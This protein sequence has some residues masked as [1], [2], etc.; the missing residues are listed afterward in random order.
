D[1][2]TLDAVVIDGYPGTRMSTYQQAGRAGRGDDPALVV[3]VGG[4]D[5]LDQYLMQSPGDFFEGD[6]ERAVCDPE[7][8]HLLPL[9]VECAAAENWLS[10][11]DDAHFGGQ[12]P[13][14]VADL[15]GADRLE[16]RD[17]DRGPRWIHAGDGSPQ[18]R[19]SLRTIDDSTIDL[20]DR[21]TNEVIASLSFA[22]GLRDAHPGAIYHHQGQSYE[23][24]SLDLARGV[25]ELQP[26]WADYYTR[27]LTEKEIKVDEDVEQKPLSARPETA[28]HFANV[29]VREQ[30]V[31]FERR[32]PRRA[33]AIGR[34][35]LALPETTLETSALYFTV[36]E[37]VATEMRAIGD[38]NGGIHAAEHGM[39]SLF[40]LSVLCDRAD[41]G[42]VSTPR[43][44]HTGRSTIF[45][46]DGYPGGVGLVRSGY[47]IVEELMEQTARLVDGCACES[48]CPACV[49]SPHCG[50]ANEPLAKEPAVVLLERLVGI[51][52]SSDPP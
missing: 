9:H 41:I 28:V 17:T 44:P 14:V 1:I 38:F 45:I 46:Y 24:K 35:S 25:A 16:R 33:E 4:E 26:T 47:D 3:L 36:P 5:Q 34:Q 37:D 8:A 18:H 30:I 29:T 39:I 10:T 7:N 6:P 51:R 50:N 52:T 40:P 13:G 2:G 43:H 21:R 19:M 23:V 15:A 49:Q 12:F 42:G 11:A 22:D 27:V 31:G 20:L 32:D 48:G